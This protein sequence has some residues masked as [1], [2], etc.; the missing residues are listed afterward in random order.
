[1]KYL[2]SEHQQTERPVPSAQE[3]TTASKLRRREAVPM[4]AS[5]CGRLRTQI[6]IRLLQ[7]D[8]LQSPNESFH[9]FHL[10]NQPNSIEPRAYLCVRT[11]GESSVG[12]N[13]QRHEKAG[14]TWHPPIA[15][16]LRLPICAKLSPVP[17]NA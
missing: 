4:D 6:N 17:D 13:N 16:V 10:Y 3:T 7:L 11:D 1:M 9:N 2:G 15:Q 5:A 14:Q 8:G 12:S